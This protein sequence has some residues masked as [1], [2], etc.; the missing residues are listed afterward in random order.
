MFP[1]MIMFDYGNTLMNEPNYNDIKGYEELL[2]YA[3]VNKYGTSAEEL[4]IG[5]VEIFDK[6]DDRIC[7]MGCDISGQLNNKIL[8]EYFGIEFS[9]TP[10]EIETVFWNGASPCYPMPGVEDMLGYLNENGIRSGVISNLNWSG[11]ALR[12]RLMSNLKNSNFDF[13]ITSSDYLFRKPYRVIFEIAL[14][15]AGL[16]AEEVWFCGDHP[17][18]D[19]DGS[20]GVG[21]YPV[22]YDNGREKGEIEP[23]SANHLYINEWHE[24]IEALEKIK[25]K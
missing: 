9:L 2:K 19:V 4:S 11:D 13:V 16:T 14:K 21:I 15:K 23:P 20:S 22:W 6:K 12:S 1:K 18:A 24:M 5:A 17:Q 7:E 8:Y 25:V 3:V 10:V